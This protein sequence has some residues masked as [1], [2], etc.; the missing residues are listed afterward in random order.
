MALGLGLAGM[1]LPE[2]IVGFL[3]VTGKWDPSLAFVLLSAV[4][5]YGVIFRLTMRRP[6]PVFDETFSV[7]MRRDITGS[8]VV[9]SLIFGAGWGITG[10]CPAPALVS[11]T[12]GNVSALVFVAAMFGGMFAFRIF[13]NY[14]ARA[15]ERAA[16]RRL[17]EVTSEQV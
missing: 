11:L 14:R 5:V 17:I 12:A 13:D 4:V 8:L 6:K 1:T 16:T 3:D 15:A 2:K 10:L 9:G 7:P